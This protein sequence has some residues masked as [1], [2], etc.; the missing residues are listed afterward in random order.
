MYSFADDTAI[1]YAS[2]NI[3][4]TIAKIETDLK[5]LNEWLLFHKICPNMGKTKA[6]IYQYKNVKTKPPDIIW[7]LPTCR[8]TPCNCN[9]IEYIYQTKY[10][11]V[12]LNTN[13]NWGEHS[14]YQQNKLRKLNYLMYH[15]RHVLPKK[16]RLKIYKAFYE[17]VLH[18]GIECWG[19]AADYI[20]QPIKIL[21]KYAVRTLVGA[22]RSD[23]TK[24]IFTSLKILPLEGL[25]E[26][27]LVSALHREAEKEVTYQPTTQH[28]QTRNHQKFRPPKKWLNKKARRQ[29]NYAIPYHF[30]NLPQ[31]LIEKLGQKSFHK[32]LKSFLLQKYSM[33]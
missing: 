20:L 5:Q 32:E 6:T 31:E 9:K 18:Y 25:Y 8:T 13:L 23:H 16:M 24:P 3:E 29:V 27:A 33:G 17:P 30:S 19:G 21:L 11:G 15:T 2:K 7:H 26:R 22:N 10:L 14:L 1:V 4:E 28:Y 12:I